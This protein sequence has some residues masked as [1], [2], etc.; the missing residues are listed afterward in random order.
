MSALSASQSAYSDK[1]LASPLLE[2]LVCPACNHRQS[3]IT[4]VAHTLVCNQCATEF[5]LFQCGDETIPWLFAQPN[6]N[7]L[8]WKAR[9]NGFLHL[10]QQAQLRLKTGQ[11]DKRLSKTGQKRI[12]KL[13]NAHQ[14]QTIQVQNLLSPLN[15]NEQDEQALNNPINAFQSK[16]P[17]VQGLTSYYDNIFRDWAWDN[18]E[19]EQMLAVIDG[20]LPVHQHLGK[21]LTIGAG[22]GRLS[23]DIH[24]QYSP[25]YSILLDINPLL[26]FA[27][28]QAIQGNRFKLNEFPI[29]PLNKDSFVKEQICHAPNSIKENIFYLLADGMN[30]PFKANSFDTIVTPWLIDI[31]PQNLRDYI[32]RI[33]SCLKTGG[34][35]LNTGSLAFFHK[36]SSWCYSEEEVVELIEKNGFEIITSKRSSL[37]YLHSPLSAHGRVE[38]VFSFHAKKI[39]DVVIP[40]KYEY[41]PDWV[42]NPDK[43]IPKQ[44]EH[45]IDSSKHLL[46]AQ[47]LGAID[48]VR[49]IE[50]IG[51]LVAKQYNLQTKE[52]THAVRRILLDHYEES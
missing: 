25:S 40:S 11:K 49:S 26:L 24:Q 37:Q 35:W 3:E 47:V 50:Q 48:G 8:E 45:E 19:N 21:L 17:K 23:Y 43:S 4:L 28:C 30:L 12:S 1:H 27:A 42:R 22:A 32:P 34:S 41:L 51:E 20:I 6:L 29:A 46:Q 10:N 36:N 14:Q 18:G 9:L 52:A 5:S 2:S 13:L 7:L 31:I 44:Y 39:K 33:N 38:S 15:L 16:I